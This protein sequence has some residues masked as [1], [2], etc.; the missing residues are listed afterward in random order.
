MGFSNE[1]KA[2]KTPLV[3]SSQT[4]GQVVD[5]DEHGFK[6]RKQM[7][8]SAN[9]SFEISFYD[10]SK[11][12]VLEVYVLSIQVSTTE[13]RGYQAQESELGDRRAL[14]FLAESFRRGSGLRDRPSFLRKKLA[15]ESAQ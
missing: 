11:T 9:L 3:A 7:V 6:K 14:L 12:K 5:V 13:S 4:A 2:E 10:G 15:V 1:C 8:G